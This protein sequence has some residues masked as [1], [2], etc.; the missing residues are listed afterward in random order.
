MYRII[1]MTAR[2]IAQCTVMLLDVA[3]APGAPQA[4]KAGLSKRVQG[5]L[6]SALEKLPE[7]GRL[8]IESGNAAVVCFVSDP[9]DGLHA[10]MLLRDEVLRHHHHAL[11]VRVALDIGEVLVASD[12][13]EQLRVT[14]DGIQHAVEIRD[15][16]RP[17]EVVVSQGYYQFLAQ[18]D[19]GLA[20]RFRFHTRG[21]TPPVPLYTAPD[22]AQPRADEARQL[23]IV[24]AELEVIEHTLERFLGPAAQSLTRDAIEGCTTLH[25]VVAAIS[26]G[27]DHPQQREVFMQ[28]LR[29]ALPERRI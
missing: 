1:R 28:A 3:L 26:A 22:A 13:N 5:L 11:S 12:P 6:G 4:D 27:I 16:A 8:A 21:E 9:Q 24:P 18:R 2:L 29:R 19:P 17:N 23:D 15:R 14:G 10:A 20:G 7:E 25:D